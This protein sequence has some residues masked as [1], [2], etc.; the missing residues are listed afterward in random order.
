[1]GGGEQ[2]SPLTELVLEA[3]SEGVTDTVVDSEECD[4]VS[5][6]VLDP[7]REVATEL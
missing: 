5:E 1:M 2:G 3:E 4:R 6:T 7:D